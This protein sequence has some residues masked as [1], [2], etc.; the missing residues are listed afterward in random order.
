[1]TTTDDPDART[2]AFLRKMAH[3]MRTPLASMLMLAE[4]L[5][6]N[7]AGRLGDRE[8][9]YARKIQRAGSEIRKLLEAVLDLTRIETGAIAAH[10]AEVPATEVVEG[11]WRIAGEQSVELDVALSD[12]LPATLATDRLQLERLLGHLLA[13]AASAGGAVGARLAAA[14]DAVEIKVGHSGT[15]IP[16]DQRAAAF[17]PFQPGQRGA[18]ALALP[19]ARALAELL[20]GDLELRSEGGADV[21]ALVLPADR[22]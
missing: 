5:A 2:A 17:E 10:R 15:P 6:D 21:F 11:L 1:M 13:H 19:I 7:A 16:E 20:G 18:S 9:G 22:L 8:V 3:E 4:L 12:D 14:G